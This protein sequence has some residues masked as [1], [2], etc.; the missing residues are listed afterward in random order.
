MRWRKKRLEMTKAEN[1]RAAKRAK[2]LG[3][4]ELEQSSN[5]QTTPEVPDGQ[6][7]KFGQGNQQATSE[8]SEEQSSSFLNQPATSQGE[9]EA[10]F[11]IGNCGSDDEEEVAPGQEKDLEE[12]P[13][14][15]MEEE[16]ECSDAQEVFDEWMLS[17]T[18]NH[19]KMLSVVLFESFCTRQGMNKMN[20]AQEAA[21]ITGQAYLFYKI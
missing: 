5:Q 3:E 19:R 7:A 4:E 15:D 18:Q 6:P 1:M 2:F 13:D 16:H 12:D 9:M 17:L 8:V 20:A 21:S 14:G 10:Y 11:A